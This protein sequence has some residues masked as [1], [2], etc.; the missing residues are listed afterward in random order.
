MRIQTCRLPIV[1]NGVLRLCLSIPQIKF[2]QWIRVYFFAAIAT[3]A[4]STAA[5][6]DAAAAAATTAT[7]V[8]RCA[9]AMFI[10]YMYGCMYN[11]NMVWFEW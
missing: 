4:T 6:A 5:A 2:R 1:M 10:L 7:D 3:A 8:G 11:C 9:N